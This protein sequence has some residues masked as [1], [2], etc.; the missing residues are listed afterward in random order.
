[1]LTTGFLSKRNATNVE[2]IFNM[3]EQETISLAEAVAIWLETG[4]FPEAAKPLL[5]TRVPE[6]MLYFKSFDS[7]C[8][9]HKDQRFVKPMKKMTASAKLEEKVKEGYPGVAW[10]VMRMLADYIDELEKK[11]K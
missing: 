5:S 1:M 2:E 10:D 6:D 4:E 9:V 7:G 11:V 3:S 8:T